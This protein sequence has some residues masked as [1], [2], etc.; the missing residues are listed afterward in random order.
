[1]RGGQIS[2]ETAPAFLL[3]VKG[4]IVKHP[5]RL[6]I[7]VPLREKRD[8]RQ[9]LVGLKNGL[10]VTCDGRTST[11]DLLPAFKPRKGQEYRLLEHLADQLN[12]GWTL[13]VWDIDRLLADLEQIANGARID[14]P[15]SAP[16]LDAAWKVISSADEEQIVDMKSFERFPDGHYVAMIAFC[17]DTDLDDY[18]LWR[19]RRLMADR[20]KRPVSEEFW[21]VLHRLIMTKSEAELAGSS[22]QRWVRN[23]RP[24]PP[25]GDLIAA[26]PAQPIL[27]SEDGPSGDNRKFEISKAQTS[28]S[29]GCASS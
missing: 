25:C 24:R 18:P 13:A 19:R 17:E 16:L 10:C 14:R 12:Q 3:I 28:A 29:D 6:L 15:K 23:N 27:R 21:G 9:T 20:P 8:F 26:E 22:Y 2:A 11:Y 4:L 1:M 7:H 5:L